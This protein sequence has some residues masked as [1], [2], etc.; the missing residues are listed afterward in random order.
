[1]TYCEFCG[2]Q[3]GYL[4]FTCKYCGGT[5]C[6]KHRLPENHECTFELKHVPVI[7]ATAK[8]SKRR[9]QDVD[10]KKV[11]S[12]EYLDQS[13][14]EL[15]KYL[16]RQERERKK[17][18]KTYET[19]QRIYSKQTQFSGTKILFSLIIIFSIVGII[20]NLYGLPQYVYLSLHSVVF[21]F[22]YHTFIT[23]LFVSDVD[24]FGFFFLIIMLLFLFFMA[25][26]IEARKGPK[27]LIKIYIISGLFTALFYILLRLAIL[28]FMPIE[29]PF[30]MV[31]LAWGGIL[32]LLSYSL[33][34]IMNQQ[35]TAMMYFLP[36]RLKGRTF[37]YIIILFRLLP[38]LLLAFSSLIYLI[39]Y[40]PDLGGILGAYIMYRFQL[41][42]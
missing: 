35:I 2:D 12:Q 21:D 9:Y 17:T 26:S 24:F 18:L 25:R 28:P 34:P 20:F 3:I 22:T 4:P 10:S 40:L 27:F 13:P 32:G 1:M 5:F 6:K 39:F 16:K 36:I 19:N 23:G 33:F 30:D 29:F 41:R 31:G 11:Y 14:R 15:R 37:L 8:S 42:R 38:G 7:T